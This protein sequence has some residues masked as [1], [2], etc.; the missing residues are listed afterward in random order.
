[1]GTRW[2][3]AIAWLCAVTMFAQ[4]QRLP[5]QTPARTAGLQGIL[6]DPSGLGLGGASITLRNLENEQSVSTTTSG[7]GVFR[8]LSLP[9]GRYALQAE[10][11][12]FERIDQ[13]VVALNGVD[14]L[15][16]EL[17]MTRVPAPARP[18]PPEPPPQPPYRTLPQPPPEG[19]PDVLPPQII[20]PRE[21]VFTP[22]PDRWKFDWP[23]YQRYG[24]IDDKAEVPYVKGHWYD[25]FN[26]N[27]L[28][29]DYPIFGQGTFLNLN[30]VS[31]TAV[32]GR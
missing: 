16:V 6:R 9:P 8:F 31:D 1:M 17:T 28:K 25:P 15:A 32:T 18:A 22:L 12:G 10:L 21:R 13:T 23:D 2:L 29:G 20:P 27:K 19:L 7:D 5:R 26:R 30:L 3:A 11:D 4:E 14:T 24:P